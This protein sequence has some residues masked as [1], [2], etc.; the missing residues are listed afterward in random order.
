MKYTLASLWFIFLITACSSGAGKPTPTL[1]R[2]PIPTAAPPNTATPQATHAAPT[3][4]G[5]DATISIWYSWD[6]RQAAALEQIMRSFQQAYPNVHFDVRYIPSENMLADYRR[7]AYSGAGPTILIGEAIW[8]PQ[9]IEDQVILDLTPFVGI[10]TEQ[11]LLPSVVELGRYNQQ[12]LGLPFTTSGI[13]LY[14]NRHI[15][16][17]AASD[18]DQLII[19]S[20][21]VTQGGIVGTDLER[22]IHFSG[23]HI[24]GLG[25]SLMI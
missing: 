8:G 15:M 3:P 10:E 18:F 6:E 7:S 22:G 2:T 5:W 12:W 21:V 9:L 1:Q 13:V 11:S 19:N 24:Y 25:G 16:S 4:V 20:Q 23:G 17:Q 14:R